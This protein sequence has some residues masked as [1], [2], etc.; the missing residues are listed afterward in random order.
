MKMNRLNNF[1]SVCVGL[2]LFCISSPVRADLIII[3][4][5]LPKYSTGVKFGNDTKFEVPKGQQ[6]QLLQT[7]EGTTHILNGPYTGTLKAYVK[8]PKSFLE[9]IGIRKNEPNLPVGGQRGPKAPAP[10]GGMRGVSR[11]DN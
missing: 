5:S 8:R 11:P 1:L 2:L 4:S 3:D 9:I 10:V 6:L 7:P